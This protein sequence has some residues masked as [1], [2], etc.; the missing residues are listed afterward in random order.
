MTS[1]P[2]VRSGVKPSRK[3]QPRTARLL[4]TS[5]GRVLRL[6]SG[7]DV[8]TYYR[9]TAL[10][11]DFGTAFRLEKL[12]GGT[13]VYDVNLLPV[14]RSTCECLGHLRHGHKTVCKHIASLSRLQQLGKL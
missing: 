12:V 14:G 3:T 11:A 7:K 6:Q 10:A 2:S 13:E 5:D 1:F 4:D 9:L 8:P